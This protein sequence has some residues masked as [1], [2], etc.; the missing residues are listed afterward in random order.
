MTVREIP[1]GETP[2]AH[3]AM[4]AL[5]PAFADPGAFA[6]EVDEVLRPEGYRL[7]GSFEDEGGDAAAVA[8]FRFGHSLAWGH[9]MYV[10][11]LATAPHARRRGHAGA[12]LDWLLEEALRQRCDQL[13]LDS[14]A[15]P[16]R[17]DAHR[18]YMTKRFAI[19][20]HHFVRML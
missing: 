17:Y 20:G 12:L 10:D 15:I 14:A 2:L 16:E 5:R 11:D 19:T 8:G 9:Y 3:A 6:R 1:A 4:S 13:H 7:A 18:L